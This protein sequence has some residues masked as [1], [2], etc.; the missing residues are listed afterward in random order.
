MVVDGNDNIIIFKD[1]TKINLLSARAK[2]EF[3]EY[4]RNA[5]IGTRKK[6]KRNDR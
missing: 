1:K 2:K 5:R 4:V 6:N 3:E